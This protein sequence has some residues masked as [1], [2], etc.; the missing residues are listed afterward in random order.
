MNIFCPSVYHFLYGM[1]S[2]NITVSSNKLKCLGLP[3]S[4]LGCPELGLG[5]RFG[6][7]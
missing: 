2:L 3:Y 4:V 6:V 5:L 1:K 7:N